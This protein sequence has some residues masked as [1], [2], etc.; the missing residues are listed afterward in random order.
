MD[1]LVST[2]WLAE[3]L[4]TVTVLDASKHL[5]A[6]GR[7]A[8]A[9]FAQGHIPGARFLDL[10]TLQDETSPVPA[11]VPRAGQFA[12]RLAALGIEDGSRVVLYDDS[13]LRSAARAWFVF[14]LFGWSD[15]AIL[16]GGLARWRAEGRALETGDAPPARAPQGPAPRPDPAR[17]RTKAEMLANLRERREQVVDARDAARFTGEAEDAVHGLPGGHIPGAR[18]LHYRALLNDDGTFKSANEL[19]AAFAAAGI[20]L[21][22]PVTTTCGS[23]VTAAVVLFALELL[24]KADIALYDG[25][26]SE[27]GADPDT[28]KEAGAVA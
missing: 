1:I 5:P 11:A 2:G 18:H 27:W 26:W 12:E 23:G 9:E 3:N 13:A 28:P 8:R 10:A 4:G 15:V 22:R 21:D 14:R 6:A 16:D 17:I 19:R 25:S 24:G 7:D 20:D